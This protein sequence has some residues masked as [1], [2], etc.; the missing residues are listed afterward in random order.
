VDEFITE[1]K[2]NPNTR[3]VFRDASKIQPDEAS[4]DGAPK[5]AFSRAYSLALAPHIIYTDSVLLKSLVS[6]KLYRQLEFQAMG[7]WWIYSKSGDASAGKLTKVPTSREDVA[8]GDSSIDMRSRRAVMKILRF[9]FDFENQ[10]EIWRPFAEAS[11][12]SFL[13]EHFKLNTETQGLLVDLFLG[14]TLD[15]RQPDEILTGD[16]LS[17]VARHIRCIGRLGAGFNAVIPKWGG[18]AEITQVACRAGAVGGGVYVLGTGVAETF[19]STTDDEALLEVKLT[20]GDLVKTKYL[21]GTSADSF[22]SLS[23]SASSDETVYKS[24]SIISD[25]LESLLPAIGDGV[26]PAG[27]VVIFPAGSLDA[28]SPPVYLIIH[29]NLTGECPNEQSKSPSL[30]SQTTRN[31]TLDM[32]INILN[33]YLHCLNSP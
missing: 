14:L 21:V 19:P 31:E 6:S 3:A 23:P 27:T 28:N 10:E 17:K 8:F 11:F 24:F 12:K 15:V 5:L 1:V 30:H 9:M 13:V 25:P 20:S 16:A 22:L 32:M 2:K 18:L 4:S 29:N 26:R 33:T 7:S